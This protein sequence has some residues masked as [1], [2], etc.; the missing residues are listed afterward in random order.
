MVMKAAVDMVRIVTGIL[1]TLIILNILFFPF[2]ATVFA[3]TFNPLIVESFAGE[4]ADVDMHARHSRAMFGAALIIIPL[5]HVALTRL[6]AIVRTVTARDPFVKENAR[7]LT[8]IAWTLLCIVL[9]DLAVGLYI[10]FDNP[11]SDR[12]SSITSWLAV[13]LLF[14]LARVFDHGTRMRD[15]LEGTV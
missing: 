3:F 9:V 14:V 8:R 4:V 12:S 13:L 2:M 1:T 11:M 6:R 7:R 10:L 15:E 5:A